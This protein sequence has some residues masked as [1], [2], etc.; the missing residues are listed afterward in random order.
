MEFTIENLAQFPLRVLPF[1]SQ[2]FPKLGLKISFLES[3]ISYCG[4]RA[5]LATLTT[6]DVSEQFIV[7]FYGSS[8]HDTI[9]AINNLATLSELSDPP[10]D[11][12]LTESLY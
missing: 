2:S 3:F 1:D 11:P 7:R 8:S 10:A 12:Q 6:T 4:G 9:L 5:A